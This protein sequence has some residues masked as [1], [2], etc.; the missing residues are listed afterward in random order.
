MNMIALVWREPRE[1][2]EVPDS[3][4]PAFWTWFIENPRSASRPSNSLPTL[5][6]HGDFDLGSLR[7]RVERGDRKHSELPA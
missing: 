7:E 5:Q 1:Q 6:M 3:S 2:S 4:Q